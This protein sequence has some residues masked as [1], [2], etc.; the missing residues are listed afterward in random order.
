MF[1]PEEVPTHKW[2]KHYL[3]RFKTVELNAPFYRW[4]Q[5]ST[6]KGWARQASPRFKYCI[7]V[8]REITH[9]RR[10]RQT[11]QLIRDFYRIAPMLGAKMG[12]FLFQFPPSFKYSVENLDLITAQLDPAFRNA[13]EFRHKSWWREDVFRT[14]TERSLIFCSISGPRFPENLIRTADQIY[15]R[16]HGKDRWYRYNYSAAELAEWAGKIR[17][18]GASTAWIYFN[19]DR[20]AHAIRNA[21]KLRALLRPAS[22]PTERKQI[23][24]TAVEPA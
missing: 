5:D 4:P 13:V 1:Y 12:C 9:E 22:L 3:S 8:N 6:I 14:F 19:N 10:L 24:D 7:K 15:I 16:F 18:S 21:R 17:A 2:F 11:E 23:A 20:D